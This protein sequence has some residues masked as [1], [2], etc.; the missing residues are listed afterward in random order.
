MNLGTPAIV[1]D[2]SLALTGQVD[3][4]LTG[5]SQGTRCFLMIQAPNG[6]AVTFSF[7]NPAC[8]ANLVGCFTLLA[9]S[10]PVLFGP[11]V[12]GNILYAK[13]TAAAVF[14]VSVG[15]AVGAA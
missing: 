8:T 1:R 7:T 12:P 15:N 4:I 5:D 11:V 6:S 9:A 14:A 10:A 3:T 13:G 2:A